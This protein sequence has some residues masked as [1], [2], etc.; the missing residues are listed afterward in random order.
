VLVVKKLPDVALSA[1]I[2]G[3]DHLTGAVCVISAPD[4]DRQRD[5]YPYV[6]GA[7]EPYWAECA[8]DALS[9]ELLVQIWHAVVLM[10]VSPAVIHAALAVI[11]EYRALMPQD[12][13]ERKR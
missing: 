9:G 4:R 10:G 6:F 8:P 5:A 1:A 7:C 2:V 11:P 13:W 12:S 3:I